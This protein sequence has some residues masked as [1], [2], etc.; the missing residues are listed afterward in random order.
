MLH[1][2]T[3]GCGSSEVQLGEALRSPAWERIRRN[4]RRFMEQAGDEDAAE[5]LGTN[6][7]E[8]WSGSN[9]FGDEFELLYLPT[10]SARY[11]E[12]E[13]RINGE[14]GIFR[15]ISYVDR[16]RTVAGSKIVMSASASPRP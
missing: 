9:T 3:R 7:L 15:A 8:L 14:K 13:A 6:P 1:L 16:S 12:L 11:L 10:S 2:Y 5:F 4:A